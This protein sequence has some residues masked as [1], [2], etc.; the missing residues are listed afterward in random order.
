DV[1]CR[2]LQS[3]GVEPVRYGLIYDPKSALD[4]LNSSGA[5][6]VVG[7]P[8]QVRAMAAFGDA[9]G[10]QNVLL[11]SD[12]TPESLADFI[13]K[14][15]SCRVFDH[16]GMTELCYG[17]A[18]DC[19]DGSGMHIRENDL[20]VEITDDSGRELSDGTPGNIVITALTGEAMPFLRYKTGDRGMLLPEKC[21]CGCEF[22][23]LCVF[24]R[25]SAA[26]AAGVTVSLTELDELV[27]KNEKIA[28]YSAAVRGER[29]VL[30]VFPAGQW[31]PRDSESLMD[32]I[33]G[34]FSGLTRENAEIIAENSYGAVN[35]SVKRVIEGLH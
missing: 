19:A 31:E 29:L 34:K 9:P 18:V 2:A 15:W 32:E 6:S 35:S 27:Y 17:G 1:L 24:G 23:R 21:A 8:Y 5:D 20:L 33:C 28:S 4:A 13:R 26:E 22:R 14:R 10:V 12:R 30:S 16:Y 11:S 7:I 25:D 3:I